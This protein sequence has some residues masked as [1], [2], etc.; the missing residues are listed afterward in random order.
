MQLRR[1]NILSI[2][3]GPEGLARGKG[4]KTVSRAG[5]RRLGELSSPDVPPPVR[6]LR[7][8]IILT[9]LAPSG[10]CESDRRELH[11]AKT[12][13]SILQREPSLIG[14]PQA[15][16]AGLHLP[17]VPRAVARRA[18]F[19]SLLGQLRAEY[20]PNHHSV[21]IPGA[22]VHHP[23]L[24]CD[25]SRSTPRAVIFFLFI[26]YSRATYQIVA[27]LFTVRF[28]S[29]VRAVF[30]CLIILAFDLGR[31]WRRTFC[32]VFLSAVRTVAAR[33]KH[34]IALRPGLSQEKVDASK[35]IDKE[36]STRKARSVPYSS[37]ADA[38][39][40][41]VGRNSGGSSPSSSCSR[42]RCP[43]SACSLQAPLCPP[44][45][46][47]PRRCKARQGN[48]KRKES[49]CERQKERKDSVLLR[50]SCR[51]HEV[52]RGEE[53]W[54]PPIARLLGPRALLFQPLPHLQLRHRAHSIVLSLSLHPPSHIRRG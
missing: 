27:R 30:F 47:V 18:S 1:T 11:V 12:S 54:S 20:L 32:P 53:H 25:C 14:L 38:M 49:E 35:E 2:Y 42:R 36:K 46:P 6:H 26:Q 51:H 8:P 24:C 41:G 37:P 22:F 9:S 34:P 13:E 33:C 43:R 39:N 28:L 21:L 40:E 45:R 15:H 16:P 10:E 3:N 17:D 29:A 31:S 52:G 5:A 44:P 50:R 19:S 23:R 48:Y 4:P 7:T